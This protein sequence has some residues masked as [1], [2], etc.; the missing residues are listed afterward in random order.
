MVNGFSIIGPDGNL[1]T[2]STTPPI[3]PPA[4][5]TI[6]LDSPF[7]GQNVSLDTLNANHYIDVLITDHSGSGLN[8]ASITDGPNAPELT[9]SGAAAAG[10]VLN[11]QA[12]QPDAVNNPNL[13]RYSFTGAFVAS[14][15]P[16]VVTFLADSFHDNNST[17]TSA[18]RSPSRSPPRRTR[19]PCPPSGSRARSTGRRSGSRRCRPGRTSTSPT[20][21]AARAARSRPTRDPRSP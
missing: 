12:T 14:T 8:V 2:V 15:S 4:P 3:P 21:P 16:V 5:P 19:Q 7:D 13:F 6:E 11:G 20:A 9:L 10:V 1:Q 18:R 17:T